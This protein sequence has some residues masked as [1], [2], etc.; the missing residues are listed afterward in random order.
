MLKDDRGEKTMSRGA[1]CLLTVV[2]CVTVLSGCSSFPTISHLHEK[3]GELAYEECKVTIL[4]TVLLGPIAWTEDC[5]DKT[6][7][8]R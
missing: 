8:L 2:G 4:N 1:R 7:K 5:Q 3:D 6:V